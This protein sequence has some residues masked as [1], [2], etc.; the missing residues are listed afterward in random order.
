MHNN[1]L[2]A[3]FCHARSAQLL[4]PT[5]I[6]D[7]GPAWLAGFRQRVPAILWGG[8]VFG[9]TYKNSLLWLF[10]IVSVT[11]QTVIADAAG[12]PAGDIVSPE[13]IDGVT[14]VDAEGLIEKVM[15]TQ[16]LVLIDSRITADR[17]EGYIEG[18]VSLPDIETDCES[19]G[20]LVPDKHAPVMFYCNGIRCGRSA[21]AAVIAKDCGYTNIF[22]FRN[23][24]EEWQEKEYPLVQ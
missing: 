3:G 16:G 4:L 7:T 21:K 10:L 8:D 17:K 12:T 15:H 22:W 18:S 20:K 19:L 6:P 11:G 9:N 13:F 1:Q 24:M 5:T 2:A 23:G 14:N